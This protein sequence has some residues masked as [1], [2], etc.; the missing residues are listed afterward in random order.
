[1]LT[2]TER[3][4]RLF[5]SRS[6]SRF[7]APASVLKLFFVEFRKRVDKNVLEGDR[8]DGDSNSRPWS[9]RVSTDQLLLSLN[10]KKKPKLSI[11][12]HRYQAN[13]QHATHRSV[14]LLIHTSANNVPDHQQ[15]PPPRAKAI[16]G[17]RT[18]DGQ[19]EEPAAR[20]TQISAVDRSAGELALFYLPLNGRPSATRARASQTGNARCVRFLFCARGFVFER[21]RGSRF[22][23]G[24]LAIVW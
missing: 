7:S 15:E 17:E 23:E 3:D 5:R 11:T 22:G 14:N 9:K 16:H 8:P 4:R 13:P 18:D 12:H 21:R 24:D 1:M 2:V 6:F 19:S 10:L 20:L